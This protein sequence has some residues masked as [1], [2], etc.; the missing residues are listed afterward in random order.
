M[1]QHHLVSRC[2]LWHQQVALVQQSS[3]LQFIAYTLK[4]Y[5]WKNMIAKPQMVARMVAEL[6]RYFAHG[7]TYSFTP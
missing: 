7:Y 3:L 1:H 6:K 5:G 4:F 2:R